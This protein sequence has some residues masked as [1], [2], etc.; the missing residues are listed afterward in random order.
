MQSCLGLMP[1]QVDLDGKPILNNKPRL[2]LG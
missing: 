1:L 2:G